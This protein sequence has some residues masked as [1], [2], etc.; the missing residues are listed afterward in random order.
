MRASTLLFE[1][2]QDAPPP[3][4]LFELWADLPG[5][6]LL[7][8]GMGHERL[9]RYSFLTCDPFLVLR[10]KNRGIEVEEGGKVQR[11]EGNPFVEL[12]RL[13][14]YYRIPQRPPGLPPFLGGVIGYFGYDLCHH[15]ERLPRTATDDL[16]VPDCWLGFYDNVLIYDW[17][18]HRAYFAA[19][20]L[21]CGERPKESLERLKSMRQHIARSQRKETRQREYIASNFTREEY[22]RA[23][24]RA[25]EYIR[26]GDIFQVNLS[27]RLTAKI[28]GSPWDLYRQLRQIN[29]APF[30]A[31]LNCR[32]VVIASASPERFLKV[33]DRKVETRP[34]KGTRPRGRTQ[35][36]DRALRAE[37]MYS[38][39]DRAELVM[40]VDLE[41]NDLGRVCEYGSVKVPE[42][43]VLEEYPTVFHLV[44]TVEG[45]LRK[46]C[47]IVDLL[48]A[49]FP[50]G[51]ITGAPKIRAM[52]II[53]E[54]EPTQRGPYTGSI[55]YIDFAGDADLNIVIRTFIMKG[56]QVH[57]Q[58][59]G[60]IVADSVPELEYEETLHKARALIKAVRKEA[61]SWNR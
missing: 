3:W 35:K 4:E 51:S 6:V 55:G 18:E 59:G 40:I 36:E 44:S 34:I 17:L 28:A 9:G 61:S 50:G 10:S 2:I 45:T 14:N 21:C 26:A 42:L 47:D 22:L 58:V 38:P 49:A 19:T 27:Q 29:P 53:D 23:V 24:E 15:I 7:D 1:E 37:L 41:R 13:L 56:D 11:F 57:F 43:I 46:E 20:T 54:L 16:C 52:E 33:R 31:Y 39:K 12:R 60:G 25:Q 8:S 48:L 32:D 30:G 5:S